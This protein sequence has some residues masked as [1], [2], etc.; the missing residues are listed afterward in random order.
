M[1]SLISRGITRLGVLVGLCMLLASNGHAQAPF[2]IGQ[3]APEFKAGR[4]VK[5][6]PITKLEPGQIYV[7]EFWATWCGPCIAAMP[8]L[9]ELAHK[10]AGKVTV[11]GVNILE[12][13]T[14]EKADRNVDRFVERKGKDIDYHVCRDTPDDYLKKHWFDPT[15]FPGIPTTIVVD[16]EGKIAWIGHPIKLDAVLDDLLAGK[17]DYEKSAAEFN[18]ASSGNEGMKKVIADYG[19]AMKAKDWTKAL[20]VIDDSPRHATTLWIARFSAL[21]HADPQQALAQAKEAGAK[22]D[23]K[24]DGFLMVIATTDDLPKELYQ[25]AADTLIKN[26]KPSDFGQLAKVAYRLGDS[27]K[28][29][30]YQLKFREFILNLPQKPGP[31]Y[32][33]QV[34]EDLR[35]YEGKQ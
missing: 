12:H 2:K 10:H 1:K 6:G 5:H 24:V 28:A 21:V 17:F 15:R 4:W 35:K 33:D 7:I 27:A 14:G 22:K 34:E 20:A 11:I 8:H 23:A 13:A 3:S 26:P 9:T 30:E 16:G 19:E 18:K 32:L 31:E 29:A 25:Y